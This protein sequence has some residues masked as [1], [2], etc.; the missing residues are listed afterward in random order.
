MSLTFVCGALRSGTT[1]FRLMLNSHPEIAN[2]A[3]CDFLFDGCRSLTAEPDLQEYIACLRTSRIFLAH[4]LEIRPE[5]DTYR[6]LVRDLVRRIGRT[7]AATGPT[8]SVSH[9]RDPFGRTLPRPRHHPADRYAPV[10]R[11]APVQRAQ[12]QR[13]RQHRPGWCI[14][15]RAVRATLIAPA[16][17]AAAQS[18]HPRD[19]T[20]GSAGLQKPSETPSRRPSP[21]SP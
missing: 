20:N 3:E 7:R 13:R 1:V 15:R 8:R 10:Y 2:P 14:N 18:L 12:R 4:E 19:R 9:R 16:P 11:A 21:H 5:C 6:A 17:P